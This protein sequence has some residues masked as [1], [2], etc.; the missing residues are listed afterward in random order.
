MKEF[1]ALVAAIQRDD[2]RNA[3]FAWAAKN[4]VELNIEH[5]EDENMPSDYARHNAERAMMEL[6]KA[7]FDKAS[8]SETIFWT[9]PNRTRITKRTVKIL[10]CDE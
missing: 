3:L 4:I 8:F 2:I 10:R 9:N 7:L 6:G 5:A 1:Y